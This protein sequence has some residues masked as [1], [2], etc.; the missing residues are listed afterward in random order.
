GMG[1]EHCLLFAEEGAVTIATDIDAEGLKET[2]AQ[3]HALGAEG[4]ALAHDVTSEADWSTVVA[5]AVDKFGRIDVLVNNAGIAHTGRVHETT[6]EDWQ[7]VM[8]INATGP[9]LGIKA[10]VPV[11]RERGGSIVNISSVY[12]LVGGAQA[13]AYNAS[14]GAVKLLTKAAAID[15]DEFGIR[16]NSVHPGLITTGMT[17]EWIGTPAVDPL[18][19]RQIQRRA[20]APREVSQ[21]VLMLASDESS[22][23]TGAE[24]AVDGGMSAR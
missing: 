4:L 3:V 19:D 15:L 9:F 6:L 20:A 12:G 22:F 21:V 1:R 11:M 17:E 7:R 23:M 14:K 24:V 13:G 2:L 18:L 16:V 8:N 5:A 10:V